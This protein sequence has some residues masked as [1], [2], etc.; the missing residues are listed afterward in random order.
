MTNI[1]T[2]TGPKTQQGTFTVGSDA[3]GEFTLNQATALNGG[4]V[5]AADKSASAQITDINA[6]DPTAATVRLGNEAQAGMNAFL[7]RMGNAQGASTS[8]ITEH[9]ITYTMGVETEVG[10]TLST[11][12]TGILALG[13][14]SAELSSMARAGNGQVIVGQTPDGKN[15]TINDRV[16]SRMQGEFKAYLQ[17]LQ[18][19]ALSN[20]TL[21]LTLSPLAVTVGAAMPAGKD[22]NM[23]NNVIANTFSGVIEWARKITSTASAEG[24]GTICVDVS[25]QLLAYLEAVQANYA[26]QPPTKGC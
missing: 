2:K 25:A 15:L 8:S 19:G 4:S 12:A 14:G 24:K 26:N 16:L 3:Q 18:R 13:T 22:A 7:Q 20:P 6:G 5:I 1:N 17:V 11:I 9:Q 10:M 21:D 23:G